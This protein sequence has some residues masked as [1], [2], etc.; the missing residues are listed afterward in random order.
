VI[1][2]E[3]QRWGELARE[4]EAALDPGAFLPQHLP[5]RHERQAIIIGQRG[6]DVGLIHGSDGAG[7][8]V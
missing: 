1:E 4:G 8:S 6:R 7:R 5:D 2:Q 3:A